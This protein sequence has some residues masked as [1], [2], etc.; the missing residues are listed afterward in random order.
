MKTKF[1]VWYMKPKWFRDGILGQLPDAGDLGKTHVH[2][3]DIELDGTNYWLGQLNS[4]ALQLEYV[5]HAMQGEVWSPNGEAR[6]LI[7]AKGLDHTS[8]SVGDVVAVDGMVFVIASFGFK[9]L[10]K[11]KGNK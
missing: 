5:F 10:A 6:E 8:M 11:A 3:K 2:L 9:E 1:A 7:E 4:G